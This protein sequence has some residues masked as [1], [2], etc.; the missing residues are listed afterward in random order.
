[1]GSCGS[2]RHNA[3]PS[4]TPAHLFPDSKGLPCS[5]DRFGSERD[6][7]QWTLR[8]QDDGRDQTLYVA[9]RG[10]ASAAQVAAAEFVIFGLLGPG[11]TLSPTIPAME[12]K[13]QDIGSRFAT[14][15]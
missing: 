14:P 15:P 7:D 8:V 11:S 4:R 5:L 10:G 13:W 3:I 12:L 9:H 6:S 1:M 2:C